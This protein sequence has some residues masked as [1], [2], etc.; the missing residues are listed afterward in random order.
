MSF[1]L[2]K[3]IKQIKMML[4]GTTISSYGKAFATLNL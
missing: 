4:Q 3:I 2:F 1:D